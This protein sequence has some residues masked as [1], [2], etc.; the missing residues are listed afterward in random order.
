[1]SKVLI[2]GGPGAT[3]RPTLITKTKEVLSIN[4]DEGDAENTHNK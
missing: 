4:P 1:M 2:S 3:L